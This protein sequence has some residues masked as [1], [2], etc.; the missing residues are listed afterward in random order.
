MY[1]SLSSYLLNVKHAIEVRSQ[2]HYR[3]FDLA[4]AFDFLFARYE[5]RNSERE[6]RENMKYWRDVGN[7]NLK[8]NLR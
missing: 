8:D 1:W 2:I 5:R 6:H 7:R 4:K 3:L